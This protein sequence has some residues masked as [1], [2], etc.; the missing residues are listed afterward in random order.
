M[1][2]VAVTL[3]TVPVTLDAGASPFNHY[4]YTMRV[5]GGSGVQQQIESDQ[6]S[7]TFED[8]VDGRYDV[9]VVAVDGNGGGVGGNAVSDQF[10]VPA[11]AEPTTFSGPSGV[12][13]VVS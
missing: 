8:V 6:T 9:L 10:A 4:V 7:V 1:S 11:D 2:S 12:T 5:I 13:V 3:D